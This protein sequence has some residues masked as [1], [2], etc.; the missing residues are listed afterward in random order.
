MKLKHVPRR[1]IVKPFDAI[2]R[3]MQERYAATADDNGN[4]SYRI[5]SD[6]FGISKPMARLIIKDGYEPKSNAIRRALDLP[7]IRLV[8]A[9]PPTKWRD[10]PVAELRWAIENRKEYNGK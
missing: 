3:R 7:T 5:V 6:T 8:R 2:R 9:N 10:L 1:P 4:K